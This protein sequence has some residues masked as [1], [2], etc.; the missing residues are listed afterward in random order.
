MG[1]YS[2]GEDGVIVVLKLDDDVVIYDDA[3]AWLETPD[4]MGEK[5]VSVFPGK[6]GVKMNEDGFIPGMPNVTFGQMFS[7]VGE[8][9]DKLLVSLETLNS[10]ANSIRAFVEN[11]GVGNDLDIVMDNLV[12]TSA[13]LNLLAGENSAKEPLRK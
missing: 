6:S 12:Q 13:K 8:I 2:L 5:V 9:K 10:A 1:D 4:L 7:A 3:Y 11:A